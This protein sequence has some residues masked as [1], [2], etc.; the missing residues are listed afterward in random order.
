MKN[1]IFRNITETQT[2]ELARQTASLL[3]A[4]ANIALCGDLGSGKTHF[5]K[6]LGH[7]LGVPQEIWIT[8]PTFTLINHYPGENY[9]FYHVD[10]YRLGNEDELF[11]IGFHDLIKGPEILAV[12][13]WDQFPETYPEQIIK[14]F[15]EKVSFETRDLEIQSEHPQFKLEQ[16]NLL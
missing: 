16:L 11:E 13:W 8:S 5:A 3:P 9:E 2:L 1:S 14:I 12:E 10:L 6:G 15:L 4:G 7:G